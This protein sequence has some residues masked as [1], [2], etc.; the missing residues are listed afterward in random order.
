MSSSLEKDIPLVTIVIPAYNEELNIEPMAQRLTKI[1]AGISKYEVIWVDDGSTDKTL[2]KL[3]SL[4]KKDPRFRYL[5][6]S[7]NFGHQMA[8]KAGLDAASGECVVSLDAD[9]QHPPELI[10]QMLKKWTEGFDVVYT[11]RK[12]VGGSI[13]KQTTSSLFYRLFSLVTF[14]QMGL[15]RGAADFRL[16]DRTVVDVLKDIKE[17]SLFLRGMIQWVGFKQ[18][19]IEYVPDKR[20]AGVSKYNPLKMFRL[21][22]DGIT[23]F[24]IL[25][26]RVSVILGLGLWLGT[27]VYVLYAV[28]AHVYLGN[29]ITGWT[30]LIVSILLTSG[31]QLFMMGIMGEYLGKLFME[32]KHRPSYIIRQA[33][34]GAPSNRRALN[35]SPHENFLSTLDSQ[36]DGLPVSPEQ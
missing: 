22:I 20:F 17:T 11:V 34:V 28:F 19:T 14:K 32:S 2:E 21:A 30:S 6:F 1:L 25:P 27:L 10:L 33:N 15:V 13:L 36:E 26:L 35:Y 24:S 9:M 7:R 31:T 12:D 29:T 3:E 16:L 5:S 18:F 4:S 23:S 8:L